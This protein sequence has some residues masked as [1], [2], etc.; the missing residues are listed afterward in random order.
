MNS[1]S[2]DYK[3]S[4]MENGVYYDNLT[5]TDVKVVVPL[6]YVSNFWRQL[7]N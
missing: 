3:A 6:K 1:R 7:D 5:K 4:F 2:F